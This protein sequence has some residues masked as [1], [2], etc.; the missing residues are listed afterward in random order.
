MAKRMCKALYSRKKREVEMVT[1]RQF[2]DNE[3]KAT[4]DKERI[5]QRQTFIL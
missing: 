5:M 1:A 3:S 2:E 4:T